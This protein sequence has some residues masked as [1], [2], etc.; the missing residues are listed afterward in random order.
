MG[1][2]NKKIFGKSLLITILTVIFLCAAALFS[3]A[4]VSVISDTKIAKA[5]GTGQGKQEVI[6][7]LNNVSDLNELEE[8]IYGNSYSPITATAVE[9]A[10]GNPVGNY[11]Y[12]IQYNDE[13]ESGAWTATAPIN[14]GRYAVRAYGAET[15][16]HIEAVSSVAYLV[17]SPRQLEVNFIDEY[18][19][20]NT[21]GGTRPYNGQ[22]YNVKAE[23]TNVVGNDKLV[24][25]TGGG[26]A[27][28]ASDTPYKFIV[29]GFSAANATV[30]AN[31]DMKNVS[32]P[33]TITRIPMTVEWSDL[34]HTYDGTQKD[35]S[36][37]WVSAEIMPSGEPEVEYAERINAG[38][39]TVNAIYNGEDSVNFEIINP[40]ELFTIERVRV[41][42][43]LSVRASYN[44]QAII[45]A[46]IHK[47]LSGPIPDA[48]ME[49][50]N[51]QINSVA[52]ETTWT[53]TS[54][55]NQAY[56][57]YLA[58]HS[59]SVYDDYELMPNYISEWHK[60]IFYPSKANVV[61][62]E[63]C[64]ND[65]T[66][67]AAEQTITAEG[68]TDF[69]G[70][71]VLEITVNKEFKN[72]ANDYI[73]TA[74]ISE[75]DAEN[76]QFGY[77]VITTKSYVIRQA[78]ATV[79][80]SDLVFTYDGTPKEL[81]ASWGE[82]EVLPMG[83]ITVNYGEMIN[84]GTYSVSAIYDGAD[85][86]NFN[87]L[88]MAAT[89][90]IHRFNLLVH[91]EGSVQY[92]QEAALSWCIYESVN[93]AIPADDADYVY[94]MLHTVVLESDWLPYSAAGQ[95]Y[96]V[97]VFGHNQEEYYDTDLLSNYVVIW[98]KGYFTASAAIVESIE[99]SDNDYTYNGTVQS[100]TAT[101]KTT[102]DMFVHL[103]VIVNKEFKNAANDYVA[104]ALI[105]VADGSNFEFGSLVIT[106]KEYEI[107]KAVVALEWDNLT[108]TYDGTQKT[109][110]VAWQSAEVVPESA[111]AVVYTE[112]INAGSFTI[113]AEYGGADK[114]NFHIVNDTE[115]MVILQRAITPIEIDTVG[116]SYFAGWFFWLIIAGTTTFG[117][118][119][120]IIL[121]K[122][123]RD[124]YAE[125]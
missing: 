98:H 93:D 1:K 54:R 116:N 51:A 109:P 108:A 102:Y 78:T 90:T 84:A 30:R 2:Q 52:F 104:T 29:Y 124:E 61:S 62:I 85:K 101:G 38:Y 103:D 56:F 75:Q 89:A 21:A 53:P 94:E 76:I 14:A 122:K 47:S 11:S 107:K 58:G 13:E 121:I 117:F 45:K 55:L 9:T 36:V 79:A 28:N 100:I 24:P 81:T 60:A 68:L 6:L 119:F 48:E 105:S 4:I 95:S 16:N 27:V 41:W 43:S 70:R 111:P 63:W 106:T 65:Y 42:I 39:Y 87:L 22:P 49:Y 96:Y 97:I 18:K 69:G 26:K 34:T 46:L 25:I 15:A 32:Y 91:L 35:P 74:A 115:T 113:Q 5:D 8:R 99:W 73:A 82:C 80:W 72:A 67:N 118:I 88:F 66:Y 57:A 77:G 33:Y 20:S 12:V 83:E 112:R 3:Q 59:E 44:N 71:I 86:D 64:E 7:T 110:T 31:Y 23:F 123:I 40:I 120:I 37:A 114:D 50:I 92:G 10:S 19:L 17:I 125:K